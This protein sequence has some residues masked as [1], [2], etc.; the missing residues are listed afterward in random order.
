MPR[1]PRKV[2]R[3]HRRLSV[4]KR[5][6]IQPSAASATP[7]RQDDG[8]CQGSCHQVPRLPR[9]AKVDATPATQSAA[10]SAATKPAQAR[11]QIQPGAASATPAMSPSAT[12]ATQSTA[13]S[14]ATKARPRRHQS[15]PSAISPTPATQN[16]GGF[17]FWFT[18][19]SV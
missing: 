14:L 11:L 15:Q 16:E 17:W 7:A 13:A 6:Q 8:R 2:P 19:G 3:R 12:P 9:E 18:S 10:A 4:P 1:L 5:H